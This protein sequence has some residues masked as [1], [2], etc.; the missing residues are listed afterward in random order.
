MGLAAGLVAPTSA[1]SGT[2]AATDDCGGC[3]P[4]EHCVN[5]CGSHYCTRYTIEGVKP[6]I[7]DCIN[8]Y[9]VQFKGATYSVKKLELK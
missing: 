9:T 3:P 6:K 4:K 1:F 8:G 5:G 7:Q 2:K